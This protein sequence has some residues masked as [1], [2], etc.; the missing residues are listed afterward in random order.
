M[1]NFLNPRKEQEANILLAVK[2]N[3]MIEKLGELYELAEKN[4]KRLLDI[5][6]N[7]NVPPNSP[8]KFNL[9]EVN[10]KTD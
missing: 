6:D 7:I 9:E 10:I 4:T 1:E 8:E 2:M 3:I 5:E